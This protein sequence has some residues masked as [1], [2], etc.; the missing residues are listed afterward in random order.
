MAKAHKKAPA[1][2]GLFSLF[3]QKGKNP[4]PAIL[5]ESRAGFLKIPPTFTTNGV[6]EQS[7]VQF[8]LFWEKTG[9]EIKKWP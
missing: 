1:Q 4:L 5:P 7:F 2:P 9:P 3:L 6:C 8:M